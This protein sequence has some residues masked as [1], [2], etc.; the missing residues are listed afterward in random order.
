M[1]APILITG[2]S[3]LIGSEAVRFFA[4]R[5]AR[6][7]G[8]DNNARRDFFGP[9]GDTSANLAALLAE[10]EHYDHRALDI[11]DRSGVART[12]REL[13]PSAVIHCAAQ[14]SHDLAK[15]RP[16][17]DFD[18]NAVGTLNLLEAVREHAPEAPFVFLSTNKVYGDAPNELPL[19]ELGSRYEYARG[20]DRF[21]VD[22]D[23]RVDASMHSLFGVSKAAADLMVQEY[24]RYFGLATVCFRAGCMSGPRHA[25]V[26]LHGFLSWLVKTAATGGTYTIIGHGGKQ[27][28]DQIHAFDVCTAIEAWLRRPRPGAVY[29]LGGGR[30]SNGSVIECLA[31][32]GELLERPVPHV[33]DGRARAG[34][35]ICYV[36]DTRRFRADHENWELTRWLPDMLEEMVRAEVDGKEVNGRDAETSQ[37]LA[38]A[39]QETLL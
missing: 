22:E 13:R 23:C 4:G 24:G 2:S 11:R 18:T 14:P 3:G 33:Y 38:E 8:L 12:V 30:E 34:D 26:E 16:F 5:G 21:G 37:S 19:V 15:K 6:V 20:K 31:M 17:D 29:N 39:G 28:R 7:V 10:V 27:V 35:H 9:G 25:G 32:V 1:N 36:S